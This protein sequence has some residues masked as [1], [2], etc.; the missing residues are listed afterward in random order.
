[1]QKE[2]STQI[3]VDDIDKNSDLKYIKLLDLFTQK[4]EI[5]GPNL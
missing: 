4:F 2:F 3:I 1:M 5:D